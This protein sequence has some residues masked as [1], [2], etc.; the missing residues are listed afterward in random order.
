MFLENLANFEWMNEPPLVSFTESGLQ[1][2]TQPLT[3]FCQYVDCGFSKKNG[4]FFFSPEKYDFVLDCKWFFESIKDSAQCGAMVQIDELNWIKIGLL[5]PNI[6]TAQIG[7]VVSQEGSSDWSMLEIPVSTSSLWFKIKRCGKDFVAYYSLD[8]DKYTTLRM[9][10]L[11]KTKQEVTAGAYACSPKKEIFECV[12]EE[13][14]LK[15]L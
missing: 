15:K 10:H 14:S 13:L 4:H 11:S 8:G 6:Y 5:S 9:V 1:I 7:V 12:L 2:S 3:D